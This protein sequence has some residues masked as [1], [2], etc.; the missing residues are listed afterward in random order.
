MNVIFQRYV[1]EKQLILLNNYYDCIYDNTKY[2][3]RVSDSTN[4]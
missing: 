1:V 4:H 2:K 3:Q